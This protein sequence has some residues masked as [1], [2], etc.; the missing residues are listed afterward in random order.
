MS[1][2][3]NF[4]MKISNYLSQASLHLRGVNVFKGVYISQYKV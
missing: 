3:C 4:N 2:H 1:E